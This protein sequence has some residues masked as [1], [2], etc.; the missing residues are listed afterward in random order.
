MNLKKW[1]CWFDFHDSIIISVKAI[2]PHQYYFNWRLKPFVNIGF[3]IFYFWSCVGPDDMTW[4]YDYRFYS[5]LHVLCSRVRPLDVH[6][7]P[8]LA[9]QT[10]F[11][12]VSLY[13]MVCHLSWCEWHMMTGWHNITILRKADME[14]GYIEQEENLHGF[15][16]KLRS[17]IY[18]FWA[19]MCK[20]S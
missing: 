18:E 14:Y 7:C 9:L 11:Y 2:R 10:V 19:V 17:T 1:T 13:L 12:I 8:S 5:R 20:L 15:Q 4:P 6:G 3:S 16:K